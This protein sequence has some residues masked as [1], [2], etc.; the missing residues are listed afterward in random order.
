[1]M[2]SVLRLPIIRHLRAIQFRRLTPLQGGATPSTAIVRYYHEQ[3]LQ[4]HASDVAGRC[5]EI[6]ETRTIRRIG[7]A[8]VT[9][10]EALDMSAHSSEITVV[11]DLSRAD[12]VPADQFDCFLNHFTM[13]VVFD[14]EAALYHSIRILRPG[15]V[16]LINFGCID[17]FLHDGLDM[18][19][20]EPL[21][22]YNWFTPLQIHDA[23]HQVGLTED[24]YEMTVYGNLFTRMA[25]QLNL[26][27]DELTA[28][29]LDTADPGH[30]VLACVRVQKP[31][32]W[33]PERPTYRTPKYTPRSE[34]KKLHPLTGHYGDTYL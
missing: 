17:Y 10:A 12:H 15:G 20:G 27:A 4:Q 2:S 28:T 7:G 34:P 29:E 3:F 21:H 9:Q 23:L 11:T 18:G 16:L 1:M 26:S 14:V 31:E 33:D 19:T 30:P 32:G 8:N 25:F 24:D 5:L 6:G 22:M 13:T